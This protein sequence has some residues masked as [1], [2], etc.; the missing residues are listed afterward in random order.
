LPKL[1]LTINCAPQSSSPHE[2]EEYSFDF[3]STATML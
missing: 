3:K 2:S 1:S